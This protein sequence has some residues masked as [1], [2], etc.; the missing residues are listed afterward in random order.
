MHTKSS[1]KWKRSFNPITFY[2]A[3]GTADYWIRHLNLDEHPEGGY[4]REVYRSGEFIQKKG[5]PARYS[6]FRPFSTSIYY[7]LK[8]SQYSAF[9]RLKSDEV[10]HFY[11]GTPLVLHIILMNGKLVTVHL[12]QDPSRKEML[13]FIIPRGSW[14]AARPAA[15]DSFSLLGCTVA[16]GFDFDDFEMGSRD[17]LIRAFPRHEQL[18]REFTS[19]P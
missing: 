3:V 1:R 19:L 4:F 10:W 9:H 8:G 15:A 12:G 16:P 5:L 17:Q 11:A 13:Q 2:R 7:L 18:I 6:G 14:F